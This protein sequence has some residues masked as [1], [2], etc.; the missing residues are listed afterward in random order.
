MWQ[1]RRQG[2]GWNP[3]DALIS[4]PTHSDSSSEVQVCVVNLSAT[5]RSDVAAEL[6]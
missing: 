2:V 4:D 6:H 5:H 3:V 1:K